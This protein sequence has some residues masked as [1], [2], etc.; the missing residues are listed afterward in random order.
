MRLDRSV[1]GMLPLAAP[2]VNLS[3]IA[4]S[5]VFGPPSR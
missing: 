1:K 2:L 5:S 3:I 4:V